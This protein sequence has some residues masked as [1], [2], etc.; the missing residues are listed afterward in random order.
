M[1]LVAFI[2]N[3]FVGKKMARILCWS[4]FISLAAQPALAQSSGGTVHVKL[5]R[6]GTNMPIGNVRVLIGKSALRETNP[7]PGFFLILIGDY[8]QSGTVRFGTTDTDGR[9]TFTNLEPGAYLVSADL[10]HFDTTAEGSDGR[11]QVSAFVVPAN[12]REGDAPHD[13]TLTLFPRA[14]VRGVVRGPDGKGIAGINVAAG[15]IEYPYRRAEWDQLGSTVQ[16]NDR[17]EYE[18]D[19]LRKGNYYIAA[20]FDRAVPPDLSDPGKQ[21]LA[22]YFPNALEFRSAR[23]VFLANGSEVVAD[24]EVPAKPATWR[25]ISGQLKSDLPD[26][27]NLT[28]FVSLTRVGD[29]LLRNTPVCGHDAATTSTSGEFV[30][31]N[32]APGTYEL[33]AT[34]LR[35]T[36]LDFRI[37]PSETRK[38]EMKRAVYSGHISVTV[39]DRNVEGLVITLNQSPTVELR[40]HVVVEGGGT[41]NLNSAN[42]ALRG[43]PGREQLSSECGSMSINTASV[44]SRDPSAFLFNFVNPGTFDFDIGRPRIGNRVYHVSDIRQSGR[45][46]YD[47][48]IEIGGGPVDPVEVVLRS[49]G[50]AVRTFVLGERGRTGMLM[51]IP[52]EPRRENPHLYE[53]INTAAQ[54]SHTFEDIEPGSYKVFAVQGVTNDN[55]ID[56]LDFVTRHESDGASVTIREGETASAQVNLVR[57]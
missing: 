1:R 57:P 46:V 3:W 35:S 39:Q 5:V 21:A 16:T 31:S 19:N 48:G 44:D 6:H 8:F 43:R 47:S 38:V 29:G 53:F 51:L 50:G 23:S 18:I 20:W 9:Y 41:I 42:I 15:V 12:L 7:P 24:I 56:V 4:F 37:G 17:G 11:V 26:T 30:I 45:S 28:Y 34:V 13:V 54:T 32:V 10:E 22:T 33:Y 2:T 40:G 55:E 27:G 52:D 49:G 25:T 36:M 14:T